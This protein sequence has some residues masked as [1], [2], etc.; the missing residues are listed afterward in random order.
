ML[1]H[2]QTR[3]VVPTRDTTPPTALEIIPEAIPAELRA[4]HQWGGWRW[5]R[6][7]G[8]WTKLPINPAT[9]DAASST[10]PSTWGTFAR[11]LDCYHR[12]HLPGI[13]Y[14]LSA[15]DPYTGI[16]IDKCRDPL[17]GALDERAAGIV[18]AL[19]SYTEISPSSTGIRIF[20]RGLV[21]GPRRKEPRLGVELYDRDRF[22][23][24]TGHALD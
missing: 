19:D 9:G 17:T 14:F 5:K 6:D 15:D 2:T 1:T 8:R 21:P 7:G 13:G 20:V 18:A 16:D 22:L 23:T 3:P 4:R 11:A 12:R 10:D 24:V